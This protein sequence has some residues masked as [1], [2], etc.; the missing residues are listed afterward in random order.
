M[1]RTVRKF[2]QSIQDAGDEHLP[3]IRRNRIDQDVTVD[4]YGVCLRKDGVFILGK[5]NPAEKL[6]NR[7]IT[8]I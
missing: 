8:E 7:F 6:V 5:I 2:T 1:K 3:F 4:I